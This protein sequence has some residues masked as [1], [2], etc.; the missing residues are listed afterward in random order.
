MN[1]LAKKEQVTATIVTPLD[2]INQANK[3]DVSIEQMQ[4]FMEMQFAWEANE[5]KK[6]FVTA[7]SK[8]RSECP[9]IIKTKEAYNSRYAG[10]AETI[11]Q[12][13]SLLSSCELSHSWKT[14]QESG[15]VKVTCVVTHSQGHS[16]STS[17]SA[18]P[19]SSG[20]KNK[21]QAIA[22]TVSYL[23]RYTL[24]A[25]L[26]LASMEMDTDGNIPSAGI[27]VNQ[28]L[29]LQALAEE[30]GADIPKFLKYMKAESFEDISSKDYAKAQAALNAK[31]KV[32]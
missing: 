10:L 11:E 22:S 20:S 4:K 23:E 14:E 27:T 5:A 18:E 29:E 31:R 32:K 19:D 15:S 17:L 7:M 1:D 8:F 26:G 28:S 16:E 30:V 12:I 2:I 21:I 9:S 25:I 3:Q 24:Y 13:K 6:A